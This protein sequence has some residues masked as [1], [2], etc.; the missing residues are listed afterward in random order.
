MFYLFFYYFDYFD[1][2]IN[3]ELNKK[4]LLIINLNYAILFSELFN[5]YSFG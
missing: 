1:N 5:E 2:Q 4:G 3:E